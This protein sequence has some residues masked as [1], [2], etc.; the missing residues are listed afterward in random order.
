MTEQERL[1]TLTVKLK[2]L[3][4][5]VIRKYGNKKSAELAP[6]FMELLKLCDKLAEKYSK[7]PAPKAA[8][9]D[10]YKAMLKNMKQT[11]RNSYFVGTFY[12]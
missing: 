12:F 9:A 10:P 4:S 8:P 3:T 11:G 6:L 2:G 1:L 5:Q 7:A